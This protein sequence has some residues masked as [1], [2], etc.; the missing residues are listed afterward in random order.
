MRIYR[1]DKKRL[2]GFAG[3]VEAVGIEGRMAFKTL[4]ELARILEL[5]RSEGQARLKGAP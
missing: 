2:N 5:K 1:D 3:L 4:E